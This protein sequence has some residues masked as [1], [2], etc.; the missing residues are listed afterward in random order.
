YWSISARAEVAFNGA[1]MGLAGGA[2]TLGGGAGACETAPS[3]REHR[4][5]ALTTTQS[6]S[7]IIRGRALLQSP[8]IRQMAVFFVSSGRVSLSQNDV[9]PATVRCLTRGFPKVS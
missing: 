5:Q 8:I 6:R 4:R 1:V 7:V 9:P 3:P 2:G